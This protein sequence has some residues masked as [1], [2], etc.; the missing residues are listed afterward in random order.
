VVRDPDDQADAIFQVLQ[1]AQPLGW[2]YRGLSW[3]PITGPAGNIEY[4]LWLDMD[5]A[6][7]APSLQAI[8]QITESA[9]SHFRDNLK[10]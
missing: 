2:Q 5:S 7:P 8:K 1:T 9:A 4:L 6:T 10:S 3:S